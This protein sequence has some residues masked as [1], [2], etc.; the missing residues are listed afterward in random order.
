MKYVMNQVEAYARIE[1]CYDSD[2]AKWT[3]EYTTKI[4]E[5][6]GDKYI[7]SRFRGNCTVEISSKTL[8][9]KMLKENVFHINDNG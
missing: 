3:F 8:Y 6:V 7:N 2:S 9:N 4:W 5:V 1:E